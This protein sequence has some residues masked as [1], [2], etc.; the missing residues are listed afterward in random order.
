MKIYTVDAYNL[1][2][3]FATVSPDCLGDPRWA[4]GDLRKVEGTF[5]A[6]HARSV[7]GMEQ[8]GYPLRLDGF[9]FRIINEDSFDYWRFADYGTVEEADEE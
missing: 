4:S 5:F 6:S 7:W 9:R 3:W 8:L 2:L 1:N